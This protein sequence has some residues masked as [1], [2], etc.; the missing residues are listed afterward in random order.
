MQPEHIQTPETV[1]KQPPR[2]RHFL[3]VFFLSFMWGSFGVDRMY[4]GKWG[5]GILKL[6]T[7]GGLGLWTLIDL[8]IIMTGTMKD[9]QGRPML[10]AQ[11]YKK[12]AWRT[13]L[14]FA[15]ALGVVILVNGLLLILGMYQLIT[16]IQDG[17]FMNLPGLDQIP[18]AEN[19]SPE[20]LQELGL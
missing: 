10:Q 2:Q 11:E 14:I 7:F 4:L 5:T 9:K 8:I 20:Q 15:I 19:L 6:V 13:V 3:A 18:G 17:N 16:S 12:F 1:Q